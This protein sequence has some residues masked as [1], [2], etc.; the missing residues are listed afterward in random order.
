[1]RSPTFTE[2]DGARR[3]GCTIRDRI[4]MTSIRT[5]RPPDSPLTDSRTVSHGMNAQLSVSYTKG[6]RG[7][8]DTPEDP[9][10]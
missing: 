2:R 8:L 4:A 3:S 10:A 7:R 9:A 6:G 1:M 5:V